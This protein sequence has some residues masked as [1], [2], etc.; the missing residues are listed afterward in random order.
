[1]KR[2]TVFLL[3]IAVLC[4]LAL[5]SCGQKDPLADEPADTAPAASAGQEAPQA[6][7]DYD[8]LIDNSFAAGRLVLTEKAI[9][10]PDPDACG[11]AAPPRSLLLSDGTPYPDETDIRNALRTGEWHMLAFSPDGKTQVGYL[12]TGNDSEQ[13][14]VL[15]RDNQVTMIYPSDK[16]GAKDTYGGMADYYSRYYYRPQ[17]NGGY[18][19]PLGI[20]DDNLTWSPDG[21][22]YYA[23]NYRFAAFLNRS[24]HYIVDTYT[25]E[26]IALD[27]F[28]PVYDRQSENPH[29]G[30]ICAGCFSPDGK[31][32]YAAGRS[33]QF[34][35]EIINCI[36]RYDLETFEA[37][38]LAETGAYFSGSSMHMLRDGTL[39]A[40]FWNGNEQS[41]FWISP[42]GTIRSARELRDRPSGSIL[43]SADSGWAVLTDKEQ[44]LGQYPTDIIPGPCLHLI[45]PDDGSGVNLDEGLFINNDTGAPE[46]ASFTGI[47]GMNS[48]DEHSH[49]QGYKQFAKFPYRFLDAA[50]SP[51]GR[52]VALLLSR[53]LPKDEV[54]LM[55]V[56]L[57]DQAYVIAEGLVIDDT[58]PKNFKIN[59]PKFYSVR[60]RK[61]SDLPILN[62]TDA[63]L[64]VIS[65]SSRLMQVA[66]N[67]LSF[68]PP[69]PEEEEPQG[70]EIH[71]TKNFDYVML[72]DGTAEIEWYHGEFTDLIV[73][74]ELDGIPVTRIG[75]EAFRP[76][77]QITEPSGL[78]STIKSGCE[79][80]VTIEISNGVTSIGEGAFFGCE[81]LERV[82]LPESVST[83]E[84]TP[85]VSCH[86]L[87]DIRIAG[88]NPWY[89]I[90]NLALF[91]KADK[92][93]I[94]CFGR[95]QEFSIPEGTLSI[96][97]GAFAG[98][99][100][101]RS[102]MIPDG[103]VSIGDSAFSGCR[104]LE[105][106]QLPDSLTSIGSFAFAGC[107]KLVSVTL[108]D[109]ISAMGDNPFLTCL[110]LTDIIVSPTHPYLE[111]IDGVLF[112]KPDRRLISYPRALA[113]EKY[114]VPDGTVIIGENAFGT[115]PALKQ[116][117]IPAS[118][119]SGPG[120]VE[121]DNPGIKIIYLE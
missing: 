54:F 36:I 101:L 10:L 120:S 93:L 27:S 105:N 14:P 13:L 99:A 49:S 34:T 79:S 21:R 90:Q 70:P 40:L 96:G 61:G 12:R 95:Y 9:P 45:R 1:M 115:V 37:E 68:P 104:N 8:S 83:I 78:K 31:Y 119:T 11:I 65:S 24:V 28:G 111:V 19:C 56:R 86:A 82:M 75:K 25:G 69:E 73:P 80:L 43:Y 51:D 91:S 52:Y 2:R 85:F 112:S 113:T 107:R 4:L 59:Y 71:E 72:E 38:L 33:N 117:S 100:A 121:D 60:S 103:L 46:T 32:F 23:A 48:I 102:V 64:L 89:E 63:G 35:G 7:S 39:L 116:L 110:K 30:I 74:A 17:V 62:W 92:Q 57:E 47:W 5:S 81:S 109:G 98:Q 84:N 106:I 97:D 20:G 67:P 16:R 26:M 77:K 18:S 3:L 118:V 22:Y 42:D 6:F 58:P 50:L 66:E 55:V 114:T 87:S 44:I 53:F 15:I 76:S 29:K 88:D 94:C 108:P 41:V